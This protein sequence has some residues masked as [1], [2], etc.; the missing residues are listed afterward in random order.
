MVGEVWQGTAQSFLACNNLGEKSIG[1]M[2]T[3]DQG[4]G[5]ASEGNP[6]LREGL[7]GRPDGQDNTLTAANLAVTGLHNAIE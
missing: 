4:R 7:I 6:I 3:I 1:P 5:K 2:I